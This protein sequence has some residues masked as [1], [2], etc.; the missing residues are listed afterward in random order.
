MKRPEKLYEGNMRKKYLLF[1]IPLILSSLLS[2][3]YGIVNSMMIGNFVGS[4][5][6]AA[7]ATTSQLLDF[8]DAIFWGYLTGVA[9][10][11]SHLFGKDE[12]QKML[13]VIKVNFI[14]S[15]VLALIVS[16]TCNIF[17]DQIF[18]LLNVGADIYDEAKA[19]FTTFISGLVIFQFNWGFIY[20]S[21]SMGMTRMP[22]IASVFSGL[23]NVALNYLFLVKLDKGIEYSALSSII[24]NL[25]VVIFYFVI[26]IRLFKGMGISL[27]G[28]KFVLSELKLA[29]DYGLPS[30]LQQMTM[31]GSTAIVS[32]LVNTC[33]TPA[34]SG[35]SIANKGRRIVTAVYQGSSKANTN[36]VA[37]AMGAKRLDKIKEGI[38]IGVTQ[39]LLLFGITMG[40]LI[41]FAPQFTSMFLDPKEDAE[42]F[43]V[44]I[45][46][47][48]FLFPFLLFNVF[49]NLLHGIF[50]AVG[51]GRLMFIS[52]L[53]YA[54][55]YVVYAN[56]LFAV[57]PQELRIY[58]VHLSLSGAY[59]TELIFA[60]VMY[61]TGK[62]KTKEY[63]ELEGKG[64]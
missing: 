54:I 21:N 52:T 40:L 5:A 20:I 29:F 19:Y 45:N 37:Q 60:A 26:Y 35:Y 33:S 31:M 16:L 3:S 8:I 57:L 22:L 58:S 42:S 11:V 23:C 48:R 6:F 18:D 1:A 64:E 4:H 46:N 61:F 56:I 2:Q 49:N 7:T 55:S 44:S 51:N 24:S 34:L 28:I 17:C 36:L 15:A 14:L 47:I 12:H 10:Y 62:W 59:L 50:R 63:R 32:P 27:K 38:R 39:G 25:V 53:I 13:N 30:M 41:L 43:I 9:I